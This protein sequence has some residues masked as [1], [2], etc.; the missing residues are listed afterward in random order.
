MPRDD[1]SGPSRQK[2]WN[3]AACGITPEANQTAVARRL[4]VIMH[5]MLRDG[6]FDS[7]HEVS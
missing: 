7:R 3:P 5:A 4:A 2:Y 1:G 6:T